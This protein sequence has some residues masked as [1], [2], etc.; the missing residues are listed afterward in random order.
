LVTALQA[1]LKKLKRQPGDLLMD[2]DTVNRRVIE[3]DVEGA[4]T[5]RVAFGEEG[6]MADCGEDG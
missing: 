3:T 1:L 4:A 6:V 2:Q 5:V